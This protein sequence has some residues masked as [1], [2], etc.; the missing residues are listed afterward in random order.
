MLENFCQEKDD[1]TAQGVNLIRLT[2]NS[3]LMKEISENTLNEELNK[4]FMVKIQFRENFT[5]LS[6]TWTSRIWNEDI[7]NVHYLSHNVSLNLK[8]QHSL[9][10]NQWADQ[11]QRERVHLCSELEMNIIFMKKATQEL[12]K[13]LKN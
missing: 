9:M 2:E 8:K 7:Q 12:V 10:A 3:N 4:L 1:G 11:A 5:P 13:K 6:T